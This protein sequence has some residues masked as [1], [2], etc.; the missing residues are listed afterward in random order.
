V[1]VLAKSQDEYVHEAVE[2]DVQ[3][4]GLMDYQKLMTQCFTECHR[5]LKPGRWMTVEFHNSQNRVWTAIQEAIQRAG[6]VVS[7]V[8]TLDKKQGSFKQYTSV[9]AVKQDLV[10]SA[11]KPS[12]TL[13]DKFAVS[14]GTDAGAWE[15]VRSHLQHIPLFVAKGGRAEVI[16]ERQ[17]YLLFDRLV[18]F[19][20]QRGFGVPMSAAEFYAGLRQRF[21]ERDS[22]YFLP[23]QV[24]EFDR[25][26]LTIKELEQLQLFVTDEKTAIQWVRRKLT[27]QPMSYQTLQPLYMREAQKVWEKHEQPLELKTILE[28]N[29]LQDGDGNWRVPDQK[30]EADLE[31]VRNRSLLREFL[32]YLDT[33]G[34]LKVVRTEALRAGF[35]ECW[36]KGDYVT[37]IQMAKRVPEAVIQED[38]ALLMYYDN[39]LMRK[40]E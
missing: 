26:R 20:V 35:K 33:K 7:D 13:E 17:A 4:K 23:E 36:Q 25:Q 22:M 9:N 19:H 14:A 29:Y 2:N 8:R 10:I 34:K 3:G 39:A 12:K 1:G 27:E 38:P 11:Y 40:G 24:P 30:K 5:V 15:F 18:A 6:F 31:Q 32:Q 37:I 21:P 28:Q 16:A